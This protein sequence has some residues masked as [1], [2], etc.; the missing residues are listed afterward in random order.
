MLWNSFQEV[1]ESDSNATGE[2]SQ[3]KKIGA[4]PFIL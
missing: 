4:D 1:D 2:S 3:S